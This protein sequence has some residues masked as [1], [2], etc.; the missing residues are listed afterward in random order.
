MR[1]EIEIPDTTINK[2]ITSTLET[3]ARLDPYGR[4]NGPLAESVKKIAEEQIQSSLSELDLSE[5]VRERVHF[6]LIPTLETIIDNQIKV[7]AKKAVRAA[8]NQRQETQ[9]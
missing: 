7:E 8:M 6:S 4:A 9:P 3:Q 1:I 2:M 5:I